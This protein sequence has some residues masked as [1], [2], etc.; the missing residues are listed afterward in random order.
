MAR[1]NNVSISVIRRLPRYHRFLEDL[2]NKGVHRI[3]SRELAQKMS[4][5]ASQIR[6]DLNCFGGFGQQGYG[7]N[8]DALYAEIGKIL[9]LDK[10]IKCVLIG[11]GHLGTAIGRHIPYES[12]G[13]NLVGVFDSD[14]RVV[15]G[16]LRGLTIKHT[17]EIENFCKLYNPKMAILCIPKDTTLEVVDRLYNCG[18]FG[19]W[20]FT[21]VDLQLFYDDI[22]VQDIHL[23]DGVMTLCYLMNEHGIPG[24]EK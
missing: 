12:Y 13:F 6:Q 23:G 15:G 20:N 14:P 3:S 7:Y 2:L 9:G 24:E 4:L 18:V 22:V 1:Y 5:T 16:E 19:Y 17:D 8:I 11:A 10:G 21:Q